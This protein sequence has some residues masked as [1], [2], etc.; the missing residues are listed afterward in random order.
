MRI[1]NQKS[2]EGPLLQVC[3]TF[4]A[5]QAHRLTIQRCL[6]SHLRPAKSS[7]K[8]CE[9][10]YDNLNDSTLFYWYIKVCNYSGILKY[11]NMPLDHIQPN[12][13]QGR[14]EWGGFPLPSSQTITGLQLVQGS[15]A[16]ARGRFKPAAL[17]LQ[18]TEH[19]TITNISPP[20]PV[21]RSFNQILWLREAT[22]GRWA[23]GAWWWRSEKLEV[24]VCWVRSWNR[25]VEIDDF[26]QVQMS[27]M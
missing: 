24:K 14:D 11:T 13:T 19:T 8:K 25:L 3:L 5:W 21:A 16:V 1:T 2:N 4:G 12:A 20:C 15:Y 22:Y 27:S 18:G 9:K 17:R 7:G 10:N 26:P 23:H 6:W